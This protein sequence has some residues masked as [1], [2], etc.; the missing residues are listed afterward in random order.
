MTTLDDVERR[1]TDGFKAVNARLD[2]QNGRVRKVELWQ[3]GMKGALG[4]LV[5]LLG[6]GAAWIAMLTRGG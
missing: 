3:A 6:S 1:V 2:V 5:V 4:L